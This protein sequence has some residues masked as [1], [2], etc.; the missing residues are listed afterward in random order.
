[1]FCAAVCLLLTLGHT[2]SAYD[3]ILNTTP[4]LCLI[5]HISGSLSAYSLCS[6]LQQTYAALREK[7][8]CQ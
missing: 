7:E 5:K 1:M 6:L 4:S 3:G 8:R 2:Y